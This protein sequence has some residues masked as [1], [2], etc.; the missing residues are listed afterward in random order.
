M[1]VNLPRPDLGRLRSV[2]D[3]ADPILRQGTVR[4]VVGLTIE[5]SGPWVQIGELCQI[6]R[7]QAGSALPAVA[8]GFREERI[9][10]M[11][12]G[13]M[14][15]VGPGSRVTAAGRRL[16]VPVGP[17]LPGRVLDGLGNLV[18]GLG[19]LG[20]VVHYPVH[21]APPEPLDRE[22]IASPLSVGVRAVDGLLT[23]G[24]GQR[25]GIFA[26]SGVGKSTLL[27]MMARNSAA[28]VNV[29]ALVGERG[30]EVRDFLENDL[31]E[32]GRQRSVLVVATSDQP[33][34]VRVN[35]AFVATAIAEYF[36]DQ[37]LDVLLMMD[38]VT[39]FAMAQREIGLATGEPPTTKGYTP[40]VFAQL[41]KL[42][43]RAGTAR[44]GSITGFYTV[45]VDGD[46]LN[47]P[48][49]DAARSILDGHIVLTRALAN[50]NH[51]PPID[52]LQSV[53]RL[54]PSV[55]SPEWLERAGRIRSVLATY[56]DAEDLVNIGAY[57]AGANPRIDRALALI[58]PINAFLTQRV[59][60]A[61]EL[62]DTGAKLGGLIDASP[63]VSW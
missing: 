8:V 4:Q 47:E 6:Q 34:M 19:P 7:N 12:L 52:V 50:R 41:P 49:A 38:S 44:R 37:G 17:D 28:A 18:D 56:R 22:P 39:R 1:A 14:D 42:L 36:R 63:G 43:E 55:V 26:G 20:A 62:A 15:G 57:V 33:A 58:D 30:R 27:G 24:K 45:L 46:D 40:S 9:L 61:A 54:M 31:G 13:E 10:L 23:C 2:L 16:T 32:A 5:S 53:S 3:S 60:E 11:P 48:I 51:Y 35:A 25:V 29:I 21:A 59:G